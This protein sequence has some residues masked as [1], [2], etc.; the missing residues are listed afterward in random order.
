[1]PL[2]GDWT[3]GKLEQP[4]GC[5]SAS[6]LVDCGVVWESVFSLHPSGSQPAGLPT[7][8]AQDSSGAE[9]E[10]QDLGKDTFFF[11]LVEVTGSGKSSLA[12]GWFDGDTCHF[13]VPPATPFIASSLTFVKETAAAA[14]R[15]TRTV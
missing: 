12:W 2:C 14:L 6:R 1:M 4:E 5:G 13:S 9:S 10:G 11:P 7:P 3:R 15:G 8:R